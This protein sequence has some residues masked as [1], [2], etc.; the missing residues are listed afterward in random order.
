M[1]IILDKNNH[2]TNY[3][4]GI[5]EDNIG[6]I[7][8]KWLPKSF[9]SSEPFFFV[10][11]EFIAERVNSFLV[12]HL[13]LFFAL[14]LTSIVSYIFFQDFIKN[15]FISTL[16]TISFIFS[17]YFYYQ[18]Q[19]HI[20]LIQVWAMVLYLKFLLKE[21]DSDKKVDYK[22][23]LLGLY[24]S[25]T[26]LLSNY[27]GLFS[28]LFTA[29]YIAS[30]SLMLREKLLLRII[31]KKT[32]I[33]LLMFTISFVTIDFKYFSANYFSV[34]DSKSNQLELKR[35]VEE[36]FIFSSRPWYYV[37][38]PEDSIFYG[39]FSKNILRILQDSFPN[40][41]FNNYFK[42]EHSS[43]YLGI[44]NLILSI[45]GIIGIKKIAE[46]KQKKELKI[47]LTVAI[48]LILFTMPP[49]IKF[50][51]LTIYTPNY[52]IYLYFP[53]FRVMARLGVLIFLIMLIFAGY[54]YKSILSSSRLKIKWRYLIAII[55][56]CISISEFIAPLKITNTSEIPEVYTFFKPEIKNN[57]AIYPNSKIRE[58]LFWTKDHNQ[59]ISNFFSGATINI[60]EVQVKT[61]D[62]NKNIN[63][64]NGLETIKQ[65]NAKYLIFFPNNQDSSEL[66]SEFFELN[67]DL[68]AKYTLVNQ[69]ENYNS[70]FIKIKNTGNVYSNSAK[71]YDLEKFILSKCKMLK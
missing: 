12:Y 57:I 40:F 48:V 66:S 25:T 18:S 27:L 62:I 60:N 69:E 24:L 44:T 6:L 15:K 19:N 10:T 50:L 46:E 55:I 26:S 29:V 64:C 2:M 37:I 42:S 5:L 63:T 47:L 53:M 39:N 21:F 33:I 8:Y 4:F 70:T 22:T 43:S 3:V 68:V 9:Y 54:G 71:I 14:L 34:S 56:F 31:F 65:L 58:G 20:I 59:N 38:A 28:I 49:F 16:L 35:S 51:N 52:L 13:T 67:L 30:K 11:F 41:L 23:Y 32:L 1:C 36:F 45:A 7:I 17:Y 61:E